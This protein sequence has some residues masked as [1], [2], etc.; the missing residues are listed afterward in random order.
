MMADGRLNVQPLISHRFPLQE[1][2]KAYEVISGNVPSLGVLLECS[3]EVDAGSTVRQNTVALS[4]RATLGTSEPVIGFLGAGAYA[5]STLIPAFARTRS[6]LRSI[7]S[8]NGITGTYF[9]RKFGFELSTTD[10]SAVLND[11][12]INTLVIATRH[13]SHA[14]YVV[15]GLR[16]GKHVFVE[17]PLAIRLDEISEIE[18]LVQV[19]NAN[20]R[21]APVL[22]VGFNRRFAPQVVR[23]KT[24]IDVVHEPKSF[25]MTVN[26]GTV[27]AEHWTRDLDSGGGRI[28]GEACHFID[29]LRFLAGAPIVEHCATAARTADACATVSLRFS[30]GSAGTVH[31][32]SNGHR[33]FPK[34]RLEIFC[35]GRVFQLDN[36]RRLTAFGWP[37]FRSMNLWRQDKGQDA[38]VGAFMTAVREGK[39]SPIP[40]EELLEVTRTTLE[41]ARLLDGQS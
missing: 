8:V 34:E 3:K 27:P 31:Y 29:L 36:F 4:V 12:Q 32:F 22:M 25:V 7:A 35:G 14:Q 10:A 13:D 19:F 2:A 28:V 11:P 39:L 18:Q 26:A 16:A 41:I 37:G 33:T 5:S 24:L 17:K 40:I 20:D 30:D 6:R 9:G 1:A 21:P 38:C 23:M 15:D